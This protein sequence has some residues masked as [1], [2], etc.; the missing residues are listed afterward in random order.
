MLGEIL[1]F[2]VGTEIFLRVAGGIFSAGDKNYKKRK[3]KNY[4]HDAYGWSK[5][6]HK[7]W[8]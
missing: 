1:A 5:D 2:G 3:K 7:G 4:Y 6:H 8:F